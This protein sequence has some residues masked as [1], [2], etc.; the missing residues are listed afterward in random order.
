M[1]GAIALVLCWEL[2]EWVDEIEG[3]GTKETLVTSISDSVRGLVH[4]AVHSHQ[5]R[6]TLWKPAV[7]GP[8]LDTSS[9]FWM[10]SQTLIG[11][12]WSIFHQIVPA[13]C[14]NDIPIQLAHGKLAC[15]CMWWVYVWW[16]SGM[17]V[18]IRYT[19]IPLYFPQAWN[20]WNHPFTWS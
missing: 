5:C 8:F 11:I 9:M 14:T 7:F 6:K 18:G 16:K 1:R 17:N 4:P 13:D 2:G 3:S 12:C 20:H 10:I 15:R 19:S